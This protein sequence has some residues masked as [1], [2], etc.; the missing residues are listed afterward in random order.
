MSYRSGTYIAFDG[1]GQVNPSL[2]DFKY[3]AMIKAWSANENF[4]FSYVDSHEKTDAVRDSSKRTTLEKRIQERLKNSKNVLIILSNQ[5]RKTESMLSFEIEQAVDIYKLP[6]II[7][8]TGVER[9]ANNIPTNRW[10]LE[11]QNKITFKQARAIH[12]PFKQ[13]PI[14][15]AIKQFD[16]NNM[17]KGPGIYYENY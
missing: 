4:E 14:I 15:W 2:S 7:V 5:T 8:Y 3:F 17:P 1:L 9:V 13:E 16:C 12:V 6:L 11:L 10:P